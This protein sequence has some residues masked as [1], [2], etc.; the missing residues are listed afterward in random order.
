MTTNSSRFKYYT[1]V[2]DST[3]S[4]PE[5]MNALNDLVNPRLDRRKG[6]LLRPTARTASIL[7]LPGPLFRRRSLF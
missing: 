4:I 5:L 1:H 2:W 6:K 3:I 7:N